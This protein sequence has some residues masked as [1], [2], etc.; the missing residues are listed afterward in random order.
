MDDI[1]PLLCLTQMIHKHGISSELKMSLYVMCVC[2]Y[3]GL[4]PDDVGKIKVHSSMWI[5]KRMTFSAHVR[6]DA[7]C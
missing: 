6:E 1:Q 4:T 3:L 2:R 7:V 5:D